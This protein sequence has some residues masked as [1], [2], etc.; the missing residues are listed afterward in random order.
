MNLSGVTAIAAGSSHA[1]AVRS[2]GTVRAWGSNQYSQL[3]TTTT[4]HCSAYQYSCSTTPVQVQSLTGVSTVA[5]GGNFSLALKSDASVWGWGENGYGQLANG[6]TKAFGGV[7]T[8]TKANLASVI[9][10][11]AGAEHTLALKSDGTV[12][13]AGSNQSGQL[14]DGTFNDSSNP[15]GV[16]NVSGVS[17]IG[18]GL[19]HSLAVGP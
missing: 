12:W 2:D 17:G 13:G 15:V 10:I 4:A 18:A 14:G 9:A 7:K 6:T 8:P 16:V 3:G 5:G 11:A 1:L 19:N